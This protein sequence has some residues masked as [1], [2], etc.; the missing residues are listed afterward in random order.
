[1]GLQAD[2]LET[3][4]RESS[5]EAVR[6]WGIALEGRLWSKL[7]DRRQPARTGAVEHGSW[8]SYDVESR[9]QATTGEDTADWENLVRAVLNCSVWISDRA[10]INCSYEFQES[11]KTNYKS[12]SHSN[13]WQYNHICLLHLR[14]YDFRVLTC[15]FL[16]RTRRCFS[17]DIRACL[18]PRY[19]Q[20]WNKLRSMALSLPCLTQRECSNYLYKKIYLI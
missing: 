18:F 15:L 13:A 14:I 4:V 1:V 3:A 6:A 5:P 2:S 10:V 11:N 12:Y 9:N 19:C 20:F 17:H 7:R 16:A 8:G